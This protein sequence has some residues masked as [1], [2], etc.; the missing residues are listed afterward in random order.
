MM[1]YKVKISIGHFADDTWLMMRTCFTVGKGSTKE[2]RGVAAKSKKVEDHRCHRVCLLLVVRIMRLEKK[3]ILN[4]LVVM[5][6]FSRQYVTTNSCR[7]ALDK[8][9]EKTGG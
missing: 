7:R 6:A 3:V 5:E 2:S 8:G 9:L 4:L 1:D